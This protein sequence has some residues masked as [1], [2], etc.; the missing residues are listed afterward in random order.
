MRVRRRALA[1]SRSAVVLAVAIILAACQTTKPNASGATAAAPGSSAL[2][3]SGPAGASPAPV[4]EPDSE[5]KIDGA[6]ESGAIDHQTALLYK[7]YAALDYGSLPE[8]YQSTNTATPEATTVL[9]ELGSGLAGLSPE[10][11]AKVEPFLLRPTDLNSFWQQR[12]STARNGSSV[13]LAAFHA[14]IEYGFEDAEKTNVRIWYAMPLG[15]SERALAAQLADEIDS[16]NMWQKEKTA[17]LGHEPCTDAGSPN[18]G[19]DGRLDIYLVYPMTGLDWGGRSDALGYDEDSNAHNGVDIFDGPGDRCP[20]TSHVIVNAT[21]D[22]A[23]LKS[24]TAHELFH[25]FQYS[26]KN[27]ILPDRNWWMEASATWAKHLVYPD[28][29]FEQAYL[30]G[31]WSQVAGTEGP[32]DNE[33]GS[34]EYGAYLLPFYLVQKS[35]DSTGTVVGRLWQASETSPPIKAVGALPAWSDSFKEFALWNWNKGAALNYHDNGAAIPETSLSQL[36]TCLDS[37]VPTGGA[38]LVKVGKMAA[39]VDVGSTSV[40]YLEGV[41]DQPLIEL[42][43]FDLTDLLD[44]PGLAIQAL[45]TLGDSNE[46]K[47]EDW[48]GLSERTFCIPSEDLRK[49]VLVV[50]NSKVTTDANVQGAVKIEAQESGCS[51]WRGTITS[52]W[53]Y[54]TVNARKGSLSATVLFQPDLTFPEHYFVTDGTA[55]WSETGN[56]GTNCSLTGGGTYSLV[57]PGDDAKDPSSR[58]GQLRIW[59]GGDPGALRYSGIGHQTAADAQYSTMTCEGSTPFEETTDAGLWLYIGSSLPKPVLGYTGEDSLTF[60][61]DARSFSGTY[62]AVSEG[63]TR[64]TWQ[65]TFEKVGD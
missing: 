23:H 22:F 61:S 15:S 28:Q 50:S 20:V 40:Q 58:A 39:F 55:T 4:L 6:E 19:G 31:A 17:M 30:N 25:A 47:V 34:A 41:P 12:A 29:N 36:T 51:G 53:D 45:V 26:F 38:C 42:L 2:G 54:G 24:T 10:M 13:S 49:I 64:Q 21:L 37:H 56:S 5:S 8:A 7:L 33:A 32:L 3:T 63:E 1:F 48:T 9:A 11:R 27:T 60:P 57:V 16:S 18:N 52:T 14:I 62:S 35:G 44:K 59:D 65:W 46:I 43:K